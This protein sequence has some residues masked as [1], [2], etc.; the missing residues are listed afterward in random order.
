MWPLQN[1]TDYWPS[2]QENGGELDFF[3]IVN[4][5]VQVEKIGSIDFS[6]SQD[7]KTYQS[8]FGKA[9]NWTSLREHPVTT[10]SLDDLKK[11]GYDVDAVINAAKAVDHPLHSP[12]LN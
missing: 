3:Q 12:I 8:Y 11:S 4:N 10:L 5:K 6:K 2:C 9:P 1:N 7:E